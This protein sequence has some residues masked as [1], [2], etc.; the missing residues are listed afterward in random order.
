MGEIVGE[1]RISAGMGSSHSRWSKVSGSAAVAS[2]VDSPGVAWGSDLEMVLWLCRW[3]FLSLVLRLGARSGCLCRT[4][5]LPGLLGPTAD[6]PFLAH[7]QAVPLILAQANPVC[8]LG[9]LAC[10]PSNSTWYG[11]PLLLTAQY[12]SKTITL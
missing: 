6:V 9:C 8:F 4:C 3:W 10:R 12:F 1:V 2:D 7:Q 11:F 5:V